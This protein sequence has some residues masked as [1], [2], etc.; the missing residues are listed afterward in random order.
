M[1]FRPAGTGEVVE[2]AY[3]LVLPLPGEQDV[4]RQAAGMAQ[5]FW[6]RV[7]QA[8]SL[9]AGFRHIAETACLQLDRAVQRLG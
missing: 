6:Q 9:S 1:A 8:T 2:R 4:W 3:A 5:D 7:A